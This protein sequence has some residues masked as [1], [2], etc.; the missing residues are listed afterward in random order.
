MDCPAVVPVTLAANNCV[1][2]AT[3]DAVLGA[4]ETLI[5]EVAGVTVTVAVSLLKASASLVATRW[6]VP[7]EAGA[8]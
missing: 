2:P 3:T 8:V 4:I 5:A 1:P 6:K 7:G